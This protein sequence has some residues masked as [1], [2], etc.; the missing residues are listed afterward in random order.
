MKEKSENK[1]KNI[2]KIPEK[3]KA[4][5]AMIKMLS[6]FFKV[7]QKSIM[8]KSGATSRKKIVEINLH[9]PEK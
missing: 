3:N 5:I 8:I 6:K 1:K 9:N 7:P 2:W 4:N